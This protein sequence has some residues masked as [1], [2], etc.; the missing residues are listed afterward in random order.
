E[1]RDHLPCANKHPHSCAHR[2][3]RK[4][5]LSLNGVEYGQVPW[6]SKTER[7]TSVERLSFAPPCASPTSSMSRRR[8]SRVPRLFLQL[9]VN[10]RRILFRV[11]SPHAL[12]L[13]VDDGVSMTSNSNFPELLVPVHI[14]GARLLLTKSWSLT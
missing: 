13:H 1:V 8:N 5:R 7:L 9:R 2:Q 14:L 10:G 4:Q 11:T 3:V 6:L 12:K